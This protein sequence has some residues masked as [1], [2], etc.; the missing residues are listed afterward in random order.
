MSSGPFA[1]SATVHQLLADTF[2]PWCSRIGFKRRLSNRC[3]FVL[4]GSAG[5][6]AF[7]V[8][9]SSW[10]NS[11]QGSQFA[12]NA[13]GG[14]F[15]PG[16]LSGPEARILRLLQGESLREAQ[17]IQAW[18]VEAH[19]A[20]GNAG[21]SWQTGN[22]NWCVYYSAAHVERWGRFLLPLLP[23]LLA[24]H[25]EKAGLPAQALT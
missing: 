22:D 8:Q 14:R 21:A 15:D 25:A 6:L 16:N 24:G 9:C 11:R 20:L 3:A 1:Q 10:G 2:G 12:L 4:E 23:A 19:P 17:M 7:E 18:I 5:S 13:A